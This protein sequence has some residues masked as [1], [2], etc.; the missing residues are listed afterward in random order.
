MA[1]DH[2]SKEALFFPE[3]KIEFVKEKCPKLA[4]ERMRWSTAASGREAQCMQPYMLL[5]APFR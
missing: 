3:R 1:S 4:I 5:G 2:Q